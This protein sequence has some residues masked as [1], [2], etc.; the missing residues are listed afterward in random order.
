MSHVTRDSPIC[1]MSDH[2]FRSSATLSPAW[3]GRNSFSLQRDSIASRLVRYVLPLV[4]PHMHV[5]VY[6]T[7]LVCLVVSVCVCLLCHLCMAAR[8]L[9]TSLTQL[10]HFDMDIPVKTSICCQW[11]K[12]LVFERFPYDAHLF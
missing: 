9:L 7:V 10:Y 2:Q 12:W 6:Y 3:W 4:K 11:S 8:Y 5:I 1:R